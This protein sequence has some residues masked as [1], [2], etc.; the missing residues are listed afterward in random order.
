M[1]NN[2]KCF[3]HISQS[4]KDKVVVSI[5]ENNNN[6]NFSTYVSIVKRFVG[7]SPYCSQRNSTSK[8]PFCKNRTIMPDIKC[9][10]F[11]KHI[12]DL[13]KKVLHLWHLI[14]SIIRRSDSFHIET[15][16]T[17]VIMQVMSIYFH[18][19][20][21]LN[22]VKCWSEIVFNRCKHFLGNFSYCRWQLGVEVI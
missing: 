9:K 19:F 20:L 15:S 13:A 12:R 22:L 17:K 16:S 14:K 10:Y 2:K 3:S 4:H 1:R 6:K 8:E 5:K 18:L 11:S 21:E 7:T